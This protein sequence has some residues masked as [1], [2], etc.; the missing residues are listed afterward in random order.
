MQ[1]EDHA[2]ISNDVRYVCTLY[3]HSI[4][5]HVASLLTNES[6]QNILSQMVIE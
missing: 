4:N 6:H 1:N 2:T 3:I 5:M